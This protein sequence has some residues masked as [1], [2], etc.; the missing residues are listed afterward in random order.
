MFSRI[1]VVQ[2]NLDDFVVTKDE[3]VGVGPVDDGVGAVVAGCKGGVE[4]GYFGPDVRDAVDEGVVRAVT[5]V[6]H[7][8]GG[9][10]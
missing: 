10:C 4:G 6:V 3:G 7:H 5:E 2:D 8:P 9:C 1:V